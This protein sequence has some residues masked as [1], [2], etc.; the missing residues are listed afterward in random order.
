MGNLPSRAVRG[1][2]RALE[3]LVAAAG[4]GGRGGSR[5]E[6][7]SSSPFVDL[8]ERLPDF[9]EREVLRRLG[10]R[11]LASL[12]GAGRGCAA[13][14]AATALMQW[15]KEENADSPSPWLPQLCWE[16]ACS[17][18][19]ERG[20]LEVVKWPHSTGCPCDTSSCSGAARQGHLEVLRWLREHDCPWNTMTCTAAASGGHLT[21]LRWAREN[22]CP[23]DASTSHCAAMEG[24]LEV[25]QWA[26]EHNCPWDEMTL[27]SP[28]W[29]GT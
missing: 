24:H 15:A 3:L 18:A 7:V 27:H 29:A 19:A 21:V 1:L 14:V 4:R 10:P 26:Q 25:L 17:R 23:W 6:G 11:D 28:H 16:V 20:Y 22:H 2:R 13:A 8:L 9:F 5:G 12:A